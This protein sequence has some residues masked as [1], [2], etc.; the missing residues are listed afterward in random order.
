MGIDADLLAILVS[1]ARRH[2]ISGRLGTLGEQTLPEPAQANA[3]LDAAG[4]R[5]SAE[6]ALQRAGFD[7]VESLDIS[8]FEGCTHIL[9]LNASPTPPHL[10]GRYDLVF[11]GGTLEHIFDTRA[12]LRN[13]FHLLSPGGVVFHASP[14]NGWVDHG[15]YQFSPTFF[16]DY[17]LANGF[18]L[19]EILLLRRDGQGATVSSYDP[20]ATIPPDQDRT[21]TVALARK[22]SSAT[23]GEVPSQS[24]YKRIYGG[25]AAKT[26]LDRRVYQPPI[27]LESGIPIFERRVETPLLDIRAAEGLSFAVH[28]PELARFSDDAG[29]PPS[30]AE[31]T[32]Q[33]QPIGPPHALH[34]CI[35]NK[36]CGRFSH[37]G[38]WLIFSTSDNE[39]PGT[40]RYSVW[41]PALETSV[42]R[43]TA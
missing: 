17:Y 34:E 24:Y 18:E 20:D 35:R 7:T 32:E 31:L 30:P 22:V 13:I 26:G 39:P 3:V 43:P 4:L 10:I 42:Q 23:S 15:F 28:L 2:R 41:M 19:L 5:P 16:L 25:D 29:G 1:A 33:G 12:A 6:P 40:R 14:T 21:L 11:D 8:D 38:E 36:G 37:W 27:R 9:D